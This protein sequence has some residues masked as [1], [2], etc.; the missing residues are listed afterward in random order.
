[1]EL[2]G[3][4]CSIATNTATAGKGAKREIVQVFSAPQPKSWPAPTKPPKPEPSP[5][6]AKTGS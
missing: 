5:P 1:M 6:P 4:G 2:I 3:K